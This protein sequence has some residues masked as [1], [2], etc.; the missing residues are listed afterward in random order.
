MR[1]G[2]AAF[3]NMKLDSLLNTQGDDGFEMR[4]PASGNTVLMPSLTAGFA[5]LVKHRLQ[6]LGAL[7]AQETSPMIEALFSRREPKTGAEGAIGWH[8]DINNP[9][10]GDDFLLHTKEIVLPNGA[11]RPYSVW[12]SGQYPKVLDGRMKV[13]SIDLRVSDPNWAVMKLRKLTSF[14]EA[15]GDFLA[16]VPGEKRQQNYSSTVAYIAEVLLARMDTLGLCRETM[17]PKVDGQV[18]PARGGSLLAGAGQQCPECH[19]LTL[20]KV[21]GCQECTSCGYVGSC[22]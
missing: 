9:V 5:A 4:H 7:E 15:R 8:V 17:Q 13:L 12:L 6:E 11:I 19:A 1:M 22:G 14:S 10:T 18:K 20:H 16:Q 3:V 2:A 21:G